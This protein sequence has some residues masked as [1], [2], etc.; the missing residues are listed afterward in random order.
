MVDL[1]R[2]WDGDGSGSVSKKEFADNMKLLGLD[3][4]KK[5]VHKLFDSMDPDGSGSLSLKELNKQL[6]RGGEVELES[7][8]RDGARGKIKTTGKV[9]I[10]AN[11]ARPAK[12]KVATKGPA[13]EPKKGAGGAVATQGR[14]RE[15]GRG[16]GEG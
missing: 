10:N 2:E 4:P 8:L 6:R 5:D 11:R 12:P 16:E 9:V 14:Y 13:A 15:G 7:E 1:F 3:V